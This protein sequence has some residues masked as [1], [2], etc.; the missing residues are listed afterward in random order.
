MAKVL[1]HLQNEKMLKDFDR[2][3]SLRAASILRAHGWIDRPE[4]EC[5]AKVRAWYPTE[6]APHSEGMS[7]DRKPYQAKKAEN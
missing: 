4:R 1:Q 6:D 5:G 7:F 2:Q 3:S